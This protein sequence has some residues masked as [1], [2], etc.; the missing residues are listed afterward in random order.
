MFKT[1]WVKIFGNTAADGANIDVRDVRSDN[2]TSA[3]VHAREQCNIGAQSLLGDSRWKRGVMVPD[4]E[5]TIPNN[6]QSAPFNQ[7][8]DTTRPSEPI[9]SLI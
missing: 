2:T 3:T 4:G 6:H 9:C 7:R 1:D 8:N 5:I